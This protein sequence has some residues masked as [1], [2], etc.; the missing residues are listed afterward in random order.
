[1]KGHKER[2]LNYLQQ[3]GKITTIEAIEKLRNT[4]LSEYI[5]QL[6][7]DGYIINNIHKTGINVFGEKCYYD[8]FVLEDNNGK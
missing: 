6:R 4:R 3:N 5:R 7:K 2:L 8:E 1:M